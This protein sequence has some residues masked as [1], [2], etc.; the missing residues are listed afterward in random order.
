M[1]LP[2]LPRPALWYMHSVRDPDRRPDTI[3]NTFYCIFAARMGIIGDF[4]GAM[5]RF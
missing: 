5:V 4:G 2:G 3:L 1:P